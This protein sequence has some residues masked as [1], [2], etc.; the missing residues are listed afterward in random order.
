MC[1]GTL[2]SCSYHILCSL[3]VLNMNCTGPLSALQHDPLPSCGLKIPSIRVFPCLYQGYS[4]NIMSVLKQICQINQI[5]Q[6][7]TEMSNVTFVL[8]P[9]R[10]LKCYHEGLTELYFIH[11]HWCF[12]HLIIYDKCTKGY[13]SEQ[14]WFFCGFIGPLIRCLLSNRQYPPHRWPLQHHV[15]CF[16]ALKQEACSAFDLLSDAK[17][18]YIRLKWL[19][20]MFIII[21]PR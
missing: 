17:L 10:P 5:Q 14:V 20:G 19:L 9:Y 6:L 11:N 13:L 8:F 12:A 21:G 2:T 3:G 4:L 1:Q 18:H 15:G 7:I 16:R